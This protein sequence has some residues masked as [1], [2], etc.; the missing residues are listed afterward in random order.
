MAARTHLSKCATGEVQK[1]L[2]TLQRNELESEKLLCYVLSNARPKKN[3][4]VTS[5]AALA[6]RKLLTIRDGG[7]EKQRQPQTVLTAH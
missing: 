5:S 2:H 7:R 3:T 4:Y 6:Y 1:V